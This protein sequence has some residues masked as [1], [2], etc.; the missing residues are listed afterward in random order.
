MV[1]II[2]EFPKNFSTNYKPGQI[3]LLKHDNL[4]LSLKEINKLI[5]KDLKKVY[6]LRGT[7]LN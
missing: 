5:S 6:H 1:H 7:S 3:F 2:T 4:T